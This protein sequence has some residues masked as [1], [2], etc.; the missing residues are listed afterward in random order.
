MGDLPPLL[1]LP[2]E[3]LNPR[4]TFHVTDGCRGVYSTRLQGSIDA[5]G[6]G[7]DNS[8]GGRV[9]EPELDRCELNHVLFL[10]GVGGLPV[11][12]SRRDLV[13]EK[14]RCFSLAP[15][16]R[17]RRILFCTLLF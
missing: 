10:R 6:G 1:K 9:T 8:S 2:S 12:R 11:N 13:R 4:L 5:G 7:G 16:F 15:V 14:K 17:Q 3:P